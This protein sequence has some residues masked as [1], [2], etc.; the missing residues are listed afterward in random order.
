MLR[1]W[2]VLARHPDFLK[3]FTGSTISLFGSSITAVALPLTAVFVLSASPFEMGLLGA[4]GFLPYLLIGLPAG[5]WVDRMPYRTVLVVADVLRALLLGLVPVLGLLGWLEM[6]QLYVIA[7]LTGVGT[8]FDSVASMSF[9]PSLVGRAH[10]LQANSA[11][12][13]SNA[14]VSVTGKALGGALVQVLTAP[15]AIVVDAVS[16]VASAA[17]KLF[18]RTPGPA[19]VE[20][21]RRQPLRSALAEGF[22]AIARQPVLRPLFVSATI[23][24]LSGQIQAA[25]VVLFLAREL[26]LPPA[27][28]GVSIAV[29]GV[30]S[31]LAAML[32]APLTERLGHGTT[33][34]VG[35]LVTALAGLVLVLAAGPLLVVMAVVVASGLLAG[36]GPPIFSINQQTVRQSLAAPEMLARINA[37]WRFLVFGTQPIGALLGGTIADV[38]GL[39][40]AIVVSSVGMLASVGVAA[41]SPLRALKTLPA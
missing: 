9:T 33:Y 1:Q 6:W 2:S 29:S 7:L 11:L 34:M 25:I 22:R 14:I 19:T 35:C 10:L 17:C 15:V 40:T 20:P 21:A 39:R 32:A 5:V 16:Y 23:G 12:A 41:W 26:G 37:T 18:I 28:V 30:A 31:V 8:L 36:A 3:L 13:Q 24:A 38:A 27:L 4:A